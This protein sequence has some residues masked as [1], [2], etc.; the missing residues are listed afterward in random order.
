MILLSF[1]IRFGAIVIKG[2]SRKRFKDPWGETGPAQGPCSPQQLYQSRGRRVV[3]TQYSISLVLQ[4]HHP[5][6]RSDVNLR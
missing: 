5:A 3:P 6:K 2:G 4:R 1:D